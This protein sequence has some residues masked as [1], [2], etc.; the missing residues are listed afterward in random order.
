MS[1]L[2]DI[3]NISS[4]HW[5]GPIQ[6]HLS[7]GNRGYETIEIPTGGILKSIPEE[8]L[9]DQVRSLT[10]QKRERPPVIALIEL[11]VKEEIKLE[12][13]KEPAVEEFSSRKRRKHKQSD[14]SNENDS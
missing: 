6:L 4:G 9:T 5:I 8:K 1:K 10:K 13:V 14:D 12:E 2:Y 11:E 7:S 3:K